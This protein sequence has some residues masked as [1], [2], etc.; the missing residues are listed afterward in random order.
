MVV[1]EKEMRNKVMDMVGT[2]ADT[3]YRKRYVTKRKQPKC[4]NYNAIWHWV[5]GLGMKKNY[6]HYSKLD[7]NPD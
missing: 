1:S 3:D 4:N 6:A 2:V 7:G 5:C